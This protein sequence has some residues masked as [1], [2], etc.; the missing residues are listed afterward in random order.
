MLDAKPPGDTRKIPSSGMIDWKAST[1]A[2]VD[3]PVR[4]RQRIGDSADFSYSSSPATNGQPKPR[5]VK[6]RESEGGS[7]AARPDIRSF[8][9]AYETRVQAAKERE[10]P[11][12]ATWVSDM[13]DAGLT[14]YSALVYGSITLTNSDFARLEDDEFYNDSIVEMYLR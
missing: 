2:I 14:L 11:P 1:N 9:R 8:G 12:D 3:D 4:K 10:P 5:P 7:P 13:Q 6:P